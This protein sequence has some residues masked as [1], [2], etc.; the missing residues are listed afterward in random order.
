V[1]LLDVSVWLAATVERHAQFRTA[2]AWFDVQQRSLALC[3]VAQMGFLRLLTN[4]SVMQQ[5]VL[6]RQEAWEVIDRLSRDP[7]VVWADEPTGLESAWRALSAG[8]DKDHK[9][10]TDDYF[11][12]FAQAV[13][14]PFATLDHRCASR[15]PSV[16]VETVAST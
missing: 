1:I 13:D 12:A 6:S 9:L 10:W 3:R 14:M 11:A 8:A 16:R 2:S 4:P 5:D 7:R 15:Y